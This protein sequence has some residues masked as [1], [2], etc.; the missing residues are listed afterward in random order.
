MGALVETWFA[1]LPSAEKRH[2]V[3]GAR[4]FPASVAWDS[5]IGA[6]GLA[7]KVAGLHVFPVLLFP[8][9]MAP[10][11]AFAANHAAALVASGDVS[12]TGMA[13][14]I[15]ANDG[16]VHAEP[17]PACPALGD[18]GT[19][20]AYL[21]FAIAASCR[22]FF[23]RC[24]AASLACQGVGFA[25]GFLANAALSRTS[26]ASRLTAGRTE[27]HFRLDGPIPAL[28][29]ARHAFFANGHAGRF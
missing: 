6:N 18:V 28:A 1:Q 23:A 22:A 12:R 13:P 9:Y 15:G 8:A 14:A 2:E 29:A 27:N 7:A 26:L 25:K 21:L 3:I 11:H 17:F 10:V 19:G 20:P 24:S 4:S 16:A 5:A